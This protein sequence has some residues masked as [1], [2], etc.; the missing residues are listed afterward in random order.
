MGRLTKPS[1]PPP[2]ETATTEHNESLRLLD[3]GTCLGQDLRKL[4][5]DGVPISSLYGS[6][7]FPEYENAGHALFRD[8]SVFT[9]GHFIAADLLDDSS[10]EN[11]LVSTEGTWDM[12]AIT[13]F[14]DI[15]GLKTQGEACRRILKLLKRR[16]GSLIVG[17]QTGNEQP[18]ELQLKPPFSAE[19]EERSVYRHNPEW[20]RMVW[21]GVGDE[22]GVRLDVQVDYAKQEGSDQLV[23]EGAVEKGK[24]K[25]FM[26][27]QDRRLVYLIRV[28]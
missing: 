12:I 18:H 21:M 23:G 5:H 22:V 13:M 19:G 11:G 4:L 9:K 27:A 10:T 20:F 2:S 3:L 15:W 24:R 14:L 8:A 28:L 1:S 25:F 17:S 6:D 16:E 7:L 26:G